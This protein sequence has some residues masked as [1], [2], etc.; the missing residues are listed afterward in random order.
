MGTLLLGKVDTCR[1]KK[2]LLLIKLYSILLFILCLNLGSLALF[3]IDMRHGD[4][5]DIQHGALVTWRQGVVNNNNDRLMFN[6]P[7]I[8][9]NRHFHS[10]AYT[11]WTFTPL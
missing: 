3:D 11:T 10:V 7:H 8:F 6:F 9:Y 5:S 1:D 4:L 2:K